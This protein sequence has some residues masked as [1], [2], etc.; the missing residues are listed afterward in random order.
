MESD[1]VDL[2]SW[3]LLDGI[4]REWYTVAQFHVLLHEFGYMRAL[5]RFQRGCVVSVVDGVVEHGHPCFFVDLIEW[6][7]DAIDVIRLEV[8]K[9][10]VMLEEWF[11]L[12]QR[13]ELG[14]I[15]DC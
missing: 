5:L 12:V 10:G 7:I 2:S 11:Q 15:A 8:I 1:G 13:A 4:H 14:A 6:I 3:D 9:G